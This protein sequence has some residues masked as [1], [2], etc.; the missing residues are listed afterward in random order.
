MYLQNRML[1]ILY[2]PKQNVLVGADVKGRLHMFDLELNLLASSP[3]TSYNKPINAIVASEKYL[4]TRDRVG[5]IGKWDIETLRPLDFQDGFSLRDD[6]YLMEGEEPS[7]SPSRG[8]GYHN[9]RVY[10]TNGYVQLTVLDAETFQVVEHLPTRNEQFYDCFCMDNPDLQ[11]ISN[12]DGEVLVGN[13]ETGEFPTVVAVDTGSVHNVRYDQRH[14]RFWATQDRGKDEY[15]WWKTGVAAF[16]PDGSDFQLYQIAEDDL[17]FLQFD[18]EYNNLYVGGF[19]GKLYIFD[20]TAREL[21]LK[22]VLGPL[23][24]QIING[25]FVSED[26]IYVLLQTG[27]VYC[28]DRMG[29]IVHRA[30]YANGCIWTMEPHPEEESQLYLGTDHGVQIIRYSAGRHKSVDIERLAKHDHGFGITK[31]VKPL[32]DGSYVAIGRMGMVFRADREGNLIWHTPIQGIPRTVG[33]NADF[34]KALA[35]TDDGIVLELNVADGSVIDRIELT[36]SV[37]GAAYALDGR[38]LLGKSKD[39]CVQV[40]APDSHEVLGTIQLTQKIKRVYRDRQGRLFSVGGDGMCE[41]DLET[42]QVKQDFNELLVNNKENGMVLGEYAHVV[43]YGYQLATYEFATGEPTDLQ[44]WLPDFSKG[45]AGRNGEDGLPILLVGGRGAYLNA[46]RVSEEGVLN[47][48]REMY[49]L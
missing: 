30:D 46:Y 4:F 37:Y 20:N 22:R 11:A 41:L 5:T 17:E 29:R 15:M 14:N 38:R 6:S 34:T 47:K 16:A 33:L 2:L 23:P 26:Q 28:L 40:Y 45:V 8:I 32:P 19:N 44:E 35:C 31:D 13:I 18:H 48:V 36:G 24:F 39:V 43:G 1:R 25:A 10:V 49:L 27:E 42:Y 3:V 7:H 9:G 21:T 12:I